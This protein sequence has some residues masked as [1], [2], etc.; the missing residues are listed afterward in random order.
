[1]IPVFPSFKKVDISDQSLIEK[2]TSQYDPYSD[3]NFVDMWSWDT[4]SQMEYAQLN[5]NLVIKVTEYLSNKY[6]YSFLGK[7]KVAETIDTL[8]EMLRGLKIANPELILVPEISLKGV[9][10]NKYY[11]EIDLNN[12]D[13]IYS[14]EDLSVYPGNK[15]SDKRRKLNSFLRN[16][17]NPTTELIDL[18]NSETR[19]QILGL[20]DVWT[21]NKSS[22]DEYHFLPKEY[23]AIE[24]FFNSNFDD[25]LCIGI[26]FETKL[27]GYSTFSLLSNEYAMC[28]F[29]KG[30]TTHYGVYEYLM[31]ESAAILLGHKVK[32]LN[33]QEDLGLPG[34]RFFKNSFN[35]S[36]FLRK[37]NIRAF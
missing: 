31:R 6:S 23:S 7:N 32:F 25:I 13:Y 1:M 18:N 29:S 15:F 14:L 5:G 24:K 2:F 16:H 20:N 26:F 10:T 17:K 3:F 4:E 37:Y 11:I 33:Y 34:L 30:D 12:Y 21:E 28:H 35:P 8:F 9:D 36:K 27:I 22:V 19:R